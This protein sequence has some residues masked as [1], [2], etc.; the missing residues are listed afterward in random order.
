VRSL[1]LKGLQLAAVKK[2]LN[3]KGLVG[4]TDEV[5]KLI[6]CY[7]GNPLAL[8]IAANSILEL[9]NG[10]ISAFIQQGTMVFNGIQPDDAPDTPDAECSVSQAPRHPV[11]NNP[12][13]FIP[14]TLSHKI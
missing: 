11:Q 14:S 2:L 7:Q 4:S 5:S 6:A 13:K 12:H 3:A 8:K 1:V 9:F 10:D